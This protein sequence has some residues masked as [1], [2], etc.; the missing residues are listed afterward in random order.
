[1]DCENG[2]SEY[3][4]GHEYGRIAFILLKELYESVQHAENH[5]NRATNILL[6]DLS[7]E[8]AKTC[9]TLTLVPRELGF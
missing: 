7:S 2:L 8:L 6:Y 9:K 1:M 3:V 4:D 5:G